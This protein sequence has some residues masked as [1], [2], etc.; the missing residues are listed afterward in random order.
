MVLCLEKDW[1]S[2]C[3][4]EGYGVNKDLKYAMFKIGF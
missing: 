1:K 2:L 3:V 4:E